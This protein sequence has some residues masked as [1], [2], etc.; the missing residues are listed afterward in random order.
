MGTIVGRTVAAGTVESAG[1][2]SALGV[3]PPQAVTTTTRMAARIERVRPKVTTSAATA[4]RTGRSAPRARRGSPCRSCVRRRQDQGA[5][6]GCFRLEVTCRLRDVGYVQCP[7]DREHGTAQVGESGGGRR[8]E[9]D[10][11]SRDVPGTYCGASMTRTFSRIAAGTRVSGWPGPSTHTRTSMSAIASGSG[12]SA[13]SIASIRSKSSISSASIRPRIRRDRRRLR[14]RRRPGRGTRWR[15]R[16]RSGHR[17]NCRRGPHDRCRA[18]RGRRSDRLGSRTRRPRSRTGRTRGC[19][20]ERPGGRHAPALGTSSSQ[21]RRSAIP[22]WSRTIGGSLA[23]A[24]IDDIEA[25]RPGR[26]R[27]WWSPR[28]GSG[29]PRSRHPERPGQASATGSTRR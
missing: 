6:V 28:N 7:G 29:W 4:P 10:R 9:G 18:R 2:S 14:P 12:G 21:A 8:G 1:T 27:R 20:I 22:A 5:R 24:F 26:P 15:C 3:M 23:I 19:R 25:G 11:A 13:D 16:R 17:A